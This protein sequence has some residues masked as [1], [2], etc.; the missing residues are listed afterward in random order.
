MRRVQISKKSKI[1]SNPFLANGFGKSKKEA[2]KTALRQMVTFL[3]QKNLIKF[4]LKDKTFLFKRPPKTI[5]LREEAERRCLVPEE[6]KRALETKRFVREISKMLN[7]DLFS[8]ACE[9]F[10]HLMSLKKVTWHEVSYL[11]TY[12]IKKK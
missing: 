7:D 12:V 10:V 1:L 4:G 9:S 8:R 11:W 3:V 5:S 2:K 6:E